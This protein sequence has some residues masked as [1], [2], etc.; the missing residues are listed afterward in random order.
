MSTIGE[1]FASTRIRGIDEG[2]GTP[3]TVQS[4]HG[5]PLDGSLELMTGTPGPAGPAGAAAH[6]FRWEGDI[7][8]QAALT[9]LAAKLSP[10]HAGKAWRV[11]ST[12]TLMYWNGSGFDSF[13]EAFGAAGPDGEPCTISLGTVDTGPVGSPL[14]ATIVG[15]APNLVLHLTVPRGVRGRKGDP[16]GPGPLRQADDYADG[17]HADGAVPV[18]SESIGKWEPRP[19]PRLRGP[20]SIVGTQAWDG[21]AGF[22]ASQSN[23]SAQSITIAQLNVP[24][25]DT[26]WR[27]VITGG[28]IVRTAAAD[29]DNRVDTEVRIGSADGQIVAFGSGFVLGLDGFC[30]L[31]PYY[32]T[33]SMTPS[34]SVGVI[35]AAQ[36]VTLYVVLRRNFGGSKFTYTQAGAQIVCWARPVI[37]Q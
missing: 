7:A 6:A 4:M 34:S 14:Q 37:T 9:A 2:I 17:P 20:W 18:W 30:Y 27:P 25:Q 13:V 21:G 5:T 19:S 33:Q 28:A 12:D 22:A 31:Q 24:A 15:T 8:D 10:A 36:P 32:A 23:I 1:Y 11:V 29:F 3:E 26:D 35:P 16:G